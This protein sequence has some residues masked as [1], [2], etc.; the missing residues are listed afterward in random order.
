M[1]YHSTKII[2]AF[3]GV[4]M[5]FAACGKD[6]DSIVGE[7]QWTGTTVHYVNSYMGNDTTYTVDYPIYKDLSFHENNKVDVM[8]MGASIPEYAP[9]YHISRYNY[10]LNA[11][12]DSIYL[13][14]PQ[15]VYYPQSWAIKSLTEKRLV[16][17]YTEE[18]GDFAGTD[19]YTTT[20]TYRRR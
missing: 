1:K 5:L 12:G 17:E 19:V 14:D 4:A 13:T 9:Y 11:A 10:R 18:A 6:N 2:A 3:L 16:L 7:W 8:Q 20:T 15:G